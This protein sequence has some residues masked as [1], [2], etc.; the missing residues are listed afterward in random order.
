M[1]I[2]SFLLFSTSV[3]LLYKGIK[4]CK[5]TSYNRTYENIIFYLRKDDNSYFKDHSNLQNNLNIEIKE[6]MKKD[7]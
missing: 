5:N 1:Y 2:C 7:W 6:F 4:N 3:F